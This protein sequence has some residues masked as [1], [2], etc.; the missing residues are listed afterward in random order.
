MYTLWQ[1][2]RA[3]AASQCAHRVT[4]LFVCPHITTYPMPDRLSVRVS[5]CVCTCTCVCVRVCVC[6]CVCVCV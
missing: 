2:E 5:V 1:H 6:V 3:Q 4:A